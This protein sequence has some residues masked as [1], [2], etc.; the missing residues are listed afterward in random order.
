MGI[1]YKLGEDV[2]GTCPNCFGRGRKQHLEYNGDDEVICMVCS[3]IIKLSEI[4]K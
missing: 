4:K 1:K 3:G 2:K